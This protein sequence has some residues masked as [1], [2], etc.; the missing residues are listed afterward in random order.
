MPSIQTLALNYL[1]FFKWQKNLYKREINFVT[2]LFLNV[3]IEEKNNSI[4]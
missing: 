2:L 4:S 1:D 3:L